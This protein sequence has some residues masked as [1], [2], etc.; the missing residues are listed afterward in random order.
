M[1][2]KPSEFRRGWKYTAA[3]ADMVVCTLLG[4][5]IGYGLD[6][7]LNTEPWMLVIWFGLGSAAGFFSVYRRMQEGMKP[8]PSDKSK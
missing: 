3:G 8:P 5:L 4:A 2:D 6:K 1:A 7:W